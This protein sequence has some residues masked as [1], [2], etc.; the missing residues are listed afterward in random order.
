MRISTAQIFDRGVDNIERQQSAL[1]R[2][3]ERIASG[4]RI[5]APSDDPVGAAQTV[6]LAHAKD[7]LGQYGANIA[8][9]KDML[10]QNDSVLSQV[11]DVLQSVRTLAVQGAN[12]ALS[13]R[14]RQSVATDVSQRLQQLL[15]L[16]NS[17][18]G[19]GAYL[20]A[21]FATSTEPFALDASG[22][23]AYNG[24]QGR[25]S[26]DVAPGRSMGVAFDGSLAFMQVRAGNGSFTATAA[27]GNA[28]T[29]TVG[30]GT[31]VD[32]S[33]LPGDT[34]RIQF[35]V[36]GPAT[37]YDVVDVTT[38]AM[39]SSGN[40]YTSGTAIAVAGMQVSVS[41]APA[42]GDTF[43]LAPSGSQSVFETLQAL[44]AALAAPAAGNPAATAAL[45]NASDSALANLDQALDHVLTLRATAGAGLRELDD[46]AT[47]NEDRDLQYDQTL[48]RLNDLDYNRALSDFARQQLALD[49]A[50]KSFAR[51]SSLSLFDYL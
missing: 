2:N 8:A 5:L 13:D 42:S 6:T 28:G 35:N 31:V 22:A 48:S 20:F 14:D 17:R 3:Q 49:A 44:A 10:S 47:G 9:A 27:P 7:R 21:G 15:S 50:Q 39:L 29:G 37:T 34:Y 32:P 11:E 46:L 24:D 51:V 45:R 38:G 36:V 43:T 12:A 40:A 18:D 23:V 19:N 26:L 30:A 33:L 16:A 41:G 1:S 4:R 25:R